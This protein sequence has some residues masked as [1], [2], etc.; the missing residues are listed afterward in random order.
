MDERIR[1]VMGGRVR[2]E[3]V[4]DPTVTVLDWLRTR[5]RRTG[6]KEGCAEGD[7]GACTVVLGEAVG[8][9][10]AERLRYRAV[11]ACILFLP[12]LDG[13][14]LFTVEDLK[15]PETGALHPV[16]QAMVDHHGSQC[17][18]CTPGFVMSLFAMAHDPEMPD[19]PDRAAIDDVLAGNLCRCTGYRPIVA[20]ARQG[21]AGGREDR[22]SAAEAT[23]LA[24][25]KDCRRP[26]G[27]GLALDRYRAPTSVAELAAVLAEAPDSQIL[28]GGT[29]VGLW[30]TKDHRALGPIVYTGAVADMA[31]VTER[32][33]LLDIGAASTYTD[34]LPALERHFPALGAMVRRLGAVQV[35][36]SGTLGGNV[37]NGSPI[38]DSM[39]PLIA[40]GTTIVLNRGGVR[41]EVVLEDFYL[42]YRQK[43]LKPGEF[44]E[45]IRIPLGPADRLVG[46]YKVSK[47]P[48]QDISAVCAG[49][50]MRLVDGKATGFRAGYGGMAAV[51]ARARACEAAIEGRPWTVDTVTAGMAA[52]ASDFTPLTDMRASADYRAMVARNLLMKFYLESTG[53]DYGLAAAKGESHG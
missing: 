36:N 29:D 28:G 23:V 6:T 37:A 3:R 4:D 8:P 9:E 42:G 39:P 10:G 53:Q 15:D 19:R 33:G 49:F 41:R 17:G 45:R 38:G 21:L 50:A 46:V 20:A 22:F 16:Q 47:R 52:L 13:K 34:A 30:V 18:F 5:E 2:T 51:P 26:P 32:D 11:N 27:R 12:T 7:C 44:V 25:L 1:F 24:L 48:D 31:D 14:A 40:L 43:D 35:R